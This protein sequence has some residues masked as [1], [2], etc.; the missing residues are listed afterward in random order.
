[1]LFSST[2]YNYEEKHVKRGKISFSPHLS[3]HDIRLGKNSTVTRGQ[4]AGVIH[5]LL[6]PAPV[7]QK[8]S[9]FYL[10]RIA[11]AHIPYSLHLPPLYQLSHF[12]FSIS[13]FPYRD[14]KAFRLSTSPQAIN[15]T[16]HNTPPSSCLTL[17]ARTLVI[18][19]LTAIHLVPTARLTDTWQ[20][21]RRKRRPT[22]RSLPSTRPPNPSRLLLTRVSAPS[23]QVHY[24]I[25]LFLCTD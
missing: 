1:M 6:L 4:W 2:E 11:T 25:V 18:V 21:S 15:Q 8:R 23:S 16:F 9:N 19:R 20:R 10:T 13:R 24:L 7:L 5:C 3:H 17:T 22:P 12:P 14:T